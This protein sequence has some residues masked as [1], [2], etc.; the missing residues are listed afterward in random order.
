[1]G[2]QARF[3]SPLGNFLCTRRGPDS[4]NPHTWDSN[5]PCARGSSGAGRAQRIAGISLK[6]LFRCP[7]RIRILLYFIHVL[8]HL[9]TLWKRWGINKLLFFSC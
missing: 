4:G 6:G 2:A 3:G 7:R 5:M 8:S 1:M 9:K